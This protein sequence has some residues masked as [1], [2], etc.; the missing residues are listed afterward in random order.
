MTRKHNSLTKSLVTRNPNKRLRGWV[1]PA[2]GW[3]TRRCILEL[4]AGG[5]WFAR[6]AVRKR[7]PGLTHGAMEYALR[8]LRQRGCLER[9]AIEGR[10]GAIA[11]ARWVY[12]ITPA[13]LAELEGLRAGTRDIIGRARSRHYA[14]LAAWMPGRGA[15]PRKTIMARLG[16]GTWRRAVHWCWHAYGNPAPVYGRYGYWEWREWTVGEFFS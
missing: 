11:K 2:P 4:A 10:A 5:A 13:G 8:G 9:K 16:P 7:H 1:P 15:M 14:A 6:P 3:H 12:R